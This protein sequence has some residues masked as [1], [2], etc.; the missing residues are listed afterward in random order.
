MNSENNESRIIYLKKITL[1]KHCVENNKKGTAGL[2][3]NRLWAFMKEAYL[4]P[5]WV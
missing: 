3:K 4:L 2:H 1:F 5:W